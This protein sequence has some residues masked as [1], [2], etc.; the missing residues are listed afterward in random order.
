[1]DFDVKTVY[2]MGFYINLRRSYPSC[3][4]VPWKDVTHLEEL[5]WQRW[6]RG[7]P[8]VYCWCAVWAKIISCHLA[9]LI[10]MCVVILLLLYTTLWAATLTVAAE[11]ISQF[12]RRGKLHLYVAT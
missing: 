7:T 8:H 3:G 4:L 11:V 6:A 1:M 9:C 2:C 10:F 12:L 5:Q